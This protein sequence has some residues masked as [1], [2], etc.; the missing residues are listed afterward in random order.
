LS[1]G[2]TVSTLPPDFRGENIVAEIILHPNGRFAY[3][4]NRGHDSL[5]AF[6]RD[7]KT[8]ALSLIGLVPCGGRH[9][10][11]FALAPDG[12]WLLCANRESNAIAV[13]SVDPSSGALSPKGQTIAVP[14]PVCVLFV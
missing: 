1:L 2:R 7:G 8:G 12:R 11:H 3:V 4:S 9:P 5:A 14:E 13:F 6:S 10:R